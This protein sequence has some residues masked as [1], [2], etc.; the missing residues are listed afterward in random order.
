LISQGL[1]IVASLIAL[2]VAA[3]AALN[4]KDLHTAG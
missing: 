1:I 3:I 4:D 2:I